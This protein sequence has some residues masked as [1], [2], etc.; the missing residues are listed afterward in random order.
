MGLGG[1]TSPEA[2]LRSRDTKESRASFREVEKELAE[3]IGGCFKRTASSA[4]VRLRFANMEEEDETAGFGER[5][6]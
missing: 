2:R 6:E 3:R 1:I 5:V 4:A